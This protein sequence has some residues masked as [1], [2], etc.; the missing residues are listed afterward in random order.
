MAL[1]GIVAEA[2]IRAADEQAKST[3]IMIFSISIIIWSTFFI[4]FW[5][6]EQV[7]FSV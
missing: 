3:M 7:L 2:M 5:K 1:I 6:R 4:E